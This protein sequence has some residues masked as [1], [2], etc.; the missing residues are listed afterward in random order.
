MHNADQTGYPTKLRHVPVAAAVA[1]ACL[2]RRHQVMD[3]TGRVRLFE[4]RALGQSE[5]ERMQKRLSETK[6]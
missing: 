3:A 5:M 6:M 2:S 4:E 1:S